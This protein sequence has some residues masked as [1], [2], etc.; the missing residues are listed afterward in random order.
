MLMDQSTPNVTELLRAWTGGDA[1]ALDRMLPMV[2][3]E[4]KRIAAGFLRRERGG[5]T[6]QAT[7]LVNEAFLRLVDVKGVSWTNRAHF[8][9]LAARMMRRILVDYARSRAGPRRGGDFQRVTLAEDRFC[10][11]GAPDELI[12]LDEAMA[13]LEKLDERKARVVEFRVFGGLDGSEIA[14]ALGVSRETVQ[15]DWRFA[16]AWLA[17]ELSGAASPAGEVNQS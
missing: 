5:H 3:E 2:H 7:A 13:R 17:R 1:Q 9:A 16:S 6:L 15:R 8:F 4:L 11:G 12:A 10:A 14:A